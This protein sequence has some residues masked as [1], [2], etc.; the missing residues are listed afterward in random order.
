MGTFIV[1]RY[2]KFRLRHKSPIKTCQYE[3]VI[4]EKLVYEY[5][6]AEEIVLVRHKML[7]EEYYVNFYFDVLQ[8]NGKHV[9]TCVNNNSQSEYK[10]S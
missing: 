8:L 2:N 7:W 5:P 9:G 10:F 6:S 3:T 1:F 4:N